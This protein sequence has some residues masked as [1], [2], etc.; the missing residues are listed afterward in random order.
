M[1][2]TDTMNTPPRISWRGLALLL[3]VAFGL[4]SLGQLHHLSERTRQL[5][6]KIDQLSAQSE[7]LA[8]GQ[9]SPGTAWESL[10][11]TSFE[12]ESGGHT[13]RYHVRTP[14]QYS[15]ASRTPLVVFYTGKGSTGAEFAAYS[16][17]EQEPVLAVYPEPL[18]GTDGATAWQGAPYS[19]RGVSDVEFTADMLAAITRDYCIDTERVYTAG[20]SNGGGIAWLS[21]CYLADTIAASVTVSGAHYQDCPEPTRPVPLLAIHSYDDH[22]VPFQG[23]ARRHLPPIDRWMRTRAQRNGCWPLPLVVERERFTRTTWPGCED[24]ATVELL[25]IR[26]EVHGWMPLPDL[27]TD[28]NLP[29]PVLSSFIWRFLS[30][31]SLP[32]Q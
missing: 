24:G 8:A 26:R 13:R 6:A 27:S 9:C 15:P 22:Q 20:M 29:S 5:E 23:H 4:T 16:G 1:L 11:T 17:F 3:L 7:A 21:A 28:P 18:V 10:T 25:A 31:H 32:S 30:Q 19:P 2:Y 14:A 12:L